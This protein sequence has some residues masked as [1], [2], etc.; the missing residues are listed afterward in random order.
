V[1]I[2]W[3]A[4]GSA[5]SKRNDTALAVGNAIGNARPEKLSLRNLMRESERTSGSL[6]IL[7]HKINQ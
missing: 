7:I 4:V 2:D 6:R 1:K 5:S 3:K